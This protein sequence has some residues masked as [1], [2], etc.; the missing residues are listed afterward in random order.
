MQPRVLWQDVLNEM[1]YVGGMS[2][3]GWF[4]GLSDEIHGF[5]ASLWGFESVC[6]SILAERALFYNPCVS[7]HIVWLENLTGANDWGNVS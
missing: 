1:G 4:V 3:I 2:S 5:G 6:R 7:I